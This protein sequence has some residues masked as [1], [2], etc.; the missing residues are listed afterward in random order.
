M[1]KRELGD[2][3]FRLAVEA[4]PNAMIMVDHEGRIILVNAQTEKLFGY[5]REELLGQSIE[6]LVPDRF[7]SA[8]PGH[9]NSFFAN[10][11]TRSMGAGRDL[12]G[13]RKDG[14]EVPVEIG[15]NPL[16]T[17]EGSFVLAA[18]VD[19]TERQRAEERFRLVV[20]S[21]PNAMIMVDDK[22]RIVLVNAQSERLFGY[23][24]QEL[25]GQ[26]IDLLVPARFRGNHPQHRSSFLA[27]P[28]P[29]PMGADRELYGIRKDGTEVQVEIGLNPIHSTE[30]AYVLA[31]IVDISARKRADAAR[32][33]LAAVVE[34]SA[35]AII[36]KSPT[37]IITSWNE[38]AQQMFGYSASEIVG[39]SIFILIPKAR[40]SEE[41]AIIEKILRGE[42]VSHFETIRRRKN[43]SLIDVSLTIS[44]IKDES[45]RIVGIS[46]ICRDI[47]ETKR[48]EER[49]RLA[50]ESAPSAMIMVDDR[51][52]IVL[53]N[54]QAEN[55]FGYSKQELLG[56]S[57]EKLVPERFRD[58]HPHHRSDFHTA[59]RSRPMGA[60]RELYAVRKDGTEVPVEI[61]LNP[62]K[63]AEGEFVLAAVVD[64]T[65]MKRMQEELVRTQSLAA[66]GEM[67]AMVAH[68]VR[69]PLAAISGPLQILADDLKADDPH[70]GLMKEILGQV[71]RLDNTVRGLL[72]IAKPF[73]PKKQLMVLR[74]LVE[75]IGRLVCEHELGRGIQFSYSGGTELSLSADPGLLE[76]VLWNLF[77]NAAEA[78][79]G[80]GEIRV[81]IRNPSHAVELTISDSGGGIPPEVL[82]KLFRPFF[83][84]KAN[85]TGLGLALCRKIV[86]AH[87]GT[88]EIQSDLGKGSTVV[89]R[90]PIP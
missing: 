60:D 50:V 7:R 33:H 58:Q 31:S 20:E 77:L 68:E 23:G 8:H 90:F 63:T 49:F 69:N 17:A 56:Q 53:A 2:D 30:G 18:V 78:M 48:A 21:A 89:L 15:L 36:T 51:G 74:Q 57:I 52:N 43:G 84:T 42:R 39:Q 10:P 28:S 81:H 35:D 37:G 80:R 5:R 88:I 55:L 76:Q 26:S 19:I 73:S 64:L 29:R 14:T 72:A 38:G 11:H 61:G 32:L 41:M 83:T 86:E 65:A 9:R 66:V 4:A 75:R 45:G 44:P 46:K 3:F 24:R 25:L 6:R 70:K 59:P 85:G 40:E 34:S 54:A 27:N 47:T 82:Q 79:K 1:S 87:R 12:F 62:I 67:A 13:R 22:G 16:K 71:N